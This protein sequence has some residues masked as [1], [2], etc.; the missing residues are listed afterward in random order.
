MVFHNSRGLDP[1]RPLDDDNWWSQSDAFTAWLFEAEYKH[2]TIAGKLSGVKDKLLQLGLVHSRE[3][4]Y[5]PAHA[6][7]MRGMA[8]VQYDQEALLDPSKKTEFTMAMLLSLRDVFDQMLDPEVSRCCFYISALQCLLSLRPASAMYTMKSAARS[9]FFY[10]E[11]FSFSFESGLTISYKTPWEIR[12]GGKPSGIEANGREKNDKF[13]AGRRSAG[14]NP[15]KDGLCL[16]QVVHDAMVEFP[17]QRQSPLWSGLPRADDNNGSFYYQNISMCLKIL[18]TK[19]GMAKELL[20]PHCFRNFV[21]FQLLA[22][23]Y[24]TTD[25]IRLTNHKDPASLAP[26]M[27]NNLATCGFAAGAALHANTIGIAHTVNSSNKRKIAGEKMR[28]TVRSPKPTHAQDPELTSPALKRMKKVKQGTIKRKI[29]LP[30]NVPK[31]A[32][33]NKP[34]TP[35]IPKNAATLV[36]SPYKRKFNTRAT[37]L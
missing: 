8:N 30:V 17:P 34:R 5:S 9:W 1:Y 3:H 23:D 2:T 11:H 22:A 36:T 18:A 32:R 29:L 15:N 14:S 19:L 26:Y 12:L 20:L 6:R 35:I 10:P 16:V 4:F 24:T 28:H 21:V 37:R 13:A 25:I 27:S 7:M 33:T 31:V